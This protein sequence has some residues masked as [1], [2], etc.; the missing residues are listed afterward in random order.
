MWRALS[1]AIFIGDP[2]WAWRRR[3]TFA[4]CAVALAGVIHA[5]WF[6]HDIA[7]ASMVMTNSW[8]AFAAT[9]AIYVGMSTGDDHLK[10][11]A[12]GQS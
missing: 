4:G 7:H 12:G 2:N 3:V 1:D 5:T 8:T 11:I 6:D 9:L 10:R